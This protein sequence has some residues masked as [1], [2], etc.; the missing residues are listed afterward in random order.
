MRKARCLFLPCPATR[1]RGANPICLFSNFLTLQL[2]GDPGR[3]RQRSWFPGA[4]T[5][6]ASPLWTHSLKFPIPTPPSHTH[7][8]RSHGLQTKRYPQVPRTRAS[9]R[10]CSRQLTWACQGSA[11]HQRSDL[12]CSSAELPPLLF[13][14]GLLSVWPR[15]AAKETQMWRV[16]AL[17]SRRLHSDSGARTCCATV[18]YTN[19]MDY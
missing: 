3:R 2:P 16:R 15:A 1:A 13:P 19:R 14:E 10:L 18:T 11:P 4:A 17:P 7:S 9:Q 5:L 12:T 8:S 6:P